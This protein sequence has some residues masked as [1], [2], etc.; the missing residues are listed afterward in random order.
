MALLAAALAVGPAQAQGTAA[1]AVERVRQITD[2]TRRQGD[3]SSRFLELPTRI[4]RQTE[5][6]GWVTITGL[7]LRDDDHN[8]RKPDDI[9]TVLIK[10]F[11]V[12]VG[13][14]IT[15]ELHYYVRG[16]KLDFDFDT[17]PGVPEP[18][19]SLQESV[20]LDLGYL[21]W[22]PDSHW[23]IRAGRQFTY[24]GR[25]L[26][27]SA[28]LDGASVAFSEGPWRTRVFAGSSLHRDPNL[29]SS[30]VG[31][32]KGTAKRHFYIAETSHTWRS[33]TRGYAYYMAQQDDSRSNSA[34]QRVFD[35]DYNSTYAGGGVEGSFHPLLNY[36][37]E[38]V[39][40]GGRMF[41]DMP[42]KRVSIDADAALAGL[43][44]YP[45]WEWHPLIT[46]E[47]AFGSGDPARSSVTGTFGGK[48]TATPD[49]NFMYFGTYDGGLAL[50]PRLSN[51]GVMRFGYQVKPFP[52]EGRRLP[53]LLV[54]GKVSTYWK[55]E[56][57]GVISDP[58]AT[59]AAHHVG[60]GLDLFVA[61]RPFSD[62]SV[63][64][65]YGNFVT[66][67]AYAPGAQDTTHRVLLTSTLTF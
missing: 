16:R 18:D 29:D 20:E 48:L 8:A 56:N 15:P 19:L 9:R 22:N 61:Y 67:S 59:L 13:G 30:I 27:L 21:D 14:E 43:L 49:Q 7:D 26:V 45:R 65:Q 46:L 37:L 54:G 32:D 62:L 23:A 31:F 41:A 11:R 52:H 4:D 66:G 60:S 40:E 47:G 17:R 64:G 10:D 44:Y 33:G 6:G 5:V 36:Y 58:L 28:D 2:A 57:S 38:A 50:S 55:N 12:W 35:F 39:H 1:T 51:L 53:G 3:E 25:A 63:L 42:K 24:V 34:A